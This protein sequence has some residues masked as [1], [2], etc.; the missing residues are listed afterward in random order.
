[1]IARAMGC[2][3]RIHDEYVLVTDVTCKLGGMTL[4]GW[5]YLDLTRHWRG[6]RFCYR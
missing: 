1:M 6:G 2:R 5:C 3:I 4:E